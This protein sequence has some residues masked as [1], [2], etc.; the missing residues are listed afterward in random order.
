MTGD[1]KKAEN[2]WN[3]PEVEWTKLEQK[4]VVAE[5]TRIGVITMMNTHLFQWDGKFYLQRKGGPIGLRAT[6]A[7]ARMTMLFW[8]EKSSKITT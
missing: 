2:S 7:V 3:I 1:V 8:D 4:L 6:C 5:M